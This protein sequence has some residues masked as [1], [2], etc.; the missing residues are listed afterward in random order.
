MTPAFSTPPAAGYSHSVALPPGRL[1][2]TSGQVGIA[3]DGTIP[4]DWE[5]QTRLVFAN[6]TDALAASG[7][8]WN[9]VVKLTWFVVSVEELALIRSIRDEHVDTA[10]PPTSS[11]IQVAGLVLPELLIEIEAVAWLPP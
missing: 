8:S 3:A 5:G 6:L 2:W 1:V 10:A 9:D 7:A 4:P 11:L